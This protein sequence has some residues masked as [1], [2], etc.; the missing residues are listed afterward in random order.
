M[1]QPGCAV[2][3]KSKHYWA[4]GG[5]LLGAF[6]A[7]AVFAF[8]SEVQAPKR[9]PL[10][11]GKLLQKQVV[12]FWWPLF[13]L[14][15]CLASYQFRS[16][17][18]ERREVAMSNRSD[19]TTCAIVHHADVIRHDACQSPTKDWRRLFLR[20]FVRGRGT[21]DEHGPP[22]K[23]TRK[24]RSPSRWAI[25][26]N[27]VLGRTHCCEAVRRGDGAR[28]PE[29]KVACCML[30]TRLLTNSMPSPC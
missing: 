6:V 28:H 24:F 18:G 11:R 13:R 5:G 14:S 1:Y 29:R 2:S 8:A 23:A 19:A 22:V 25:E 15:A 3:L 26:A 20:E 4:T 9:T 7:Y 16:K 30:I 10:T 12:R 21:P 17:D 27:E